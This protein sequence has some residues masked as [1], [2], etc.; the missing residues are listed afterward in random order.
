[1]KQECMW[2]P[3]LFPNKVFIVWAAGFYNNGVK[4]YG[5]GSVV[6]FSQMRQC[7]CYNVCGLARQCFLLFGEER[8]CKCQCGQ[9]LGCSWFTIFLAKLSWVQIF[10]NLASGVLL[11]RPIQHGG[12]G[13][14]VPAQ[15]Y[16]GGHAR[17]Q[18]CPSFVSRIICTP[19]KR[20]QIRKDTFQRVQCHNVDLTR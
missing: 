5:V 13:G 10:V 15:H 7:C 18:S 11:L 17:K 3:I 20:A 6:R 19:R 12:G 14:L 4:F 2:L 16:Y 8:I 1:M 9:F